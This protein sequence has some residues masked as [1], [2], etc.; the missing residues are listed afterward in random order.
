ME[1]HSEGLP[2]ICTRKRWD[3]DTGTP[4][5]AS[6]MPRRQLDQCGAR[7][8][9]LDNRMQK[10]PEAPELACGRGQDPMVDSQMGSSGD[11]ATPILW[12]FCQHPQCFTASW[13][14]R[15]FIQKQGL[16]KLYRVSAAENSAPAS[17]PLPQLPAGS[18]LWVALCQAQPVHSSQKGISGSSRNLQGGG[19]R[20]M[21]PSHPHP[22]P[23]SLI[24][25]GGPVGWEALRDGECMSDPLKW[26]H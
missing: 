12:R 7:G 23:S 16:K 15:I 3:K 25:T 20:S 4:L 9:R 19:E 21:A 1:R 11:S 2:D 8:R 6:E 13:S 18:P 10:G 14:L 5:P 17:M 26:G 22:R 24:P